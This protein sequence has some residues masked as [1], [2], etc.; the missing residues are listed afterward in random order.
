M[1]TSSVTTVYIGNFVINLILKAGLNELL[2]SIQTMQIILHY[3]L[4]NVKLAPNAQIFYAHLFVVFAFDVFETRD[5]MT[6]FLNLQDSEP[7][8]E[9]FESLGYE[10]SYYS[11][12]IGSITLFVIL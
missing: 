4:V 11:I 12:N 8:N 9:N 6:E 3:S 10:T 5:F 1:V 2:S 7:Y